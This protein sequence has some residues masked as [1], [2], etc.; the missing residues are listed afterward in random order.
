MT[1]SHIENKIQQLSEKIRLAHKNHQ[2]LAISGNGSKYFYGHQVQ[3]ED[4][5]STELSGIINYHPSELVIT[6]YAGTPLH[7]I[8][9]ALNANNQMLAFEPPTCRGKATLGGA[10]ASGFSGPRR[11]FAGAA[12]DYMLGCRII[13]G[14]GEVLRFGGEVIKNVAGY[15]VSRLMCGAF[16]TLGLLIEVSLKV[17]PVA[18]CEVTTSFELDKHKSIE[19]VNHL[20]TQGAPLSASCIYD[21]VLSIRFSGSR[22]AVD[23]TVQSLGGDVIE[24]AD[25]FWL[26]IQEQGHDFFNHS[27][28]LWRI[29]VPPTTSSI[30]LEGDEL[31]E[32]YGGLR[33]LRTNAESNEIHR[34]TNAL[35]GHATLYKTANESADFRFSPLS[36][37]VLRLHKNLKHAFDPRKILNP[38]KLYPEI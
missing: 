38:K 11:A 13:N 5:F 30:D 9:A 33:W 4:I 7:E 22:I 16:G 6:A 23:K 29:S 35:G 25:D 27:E 20:A 14:K 36:K 21:G 32:W 8:N 26:G 28:D 19:F 2:A 17:V 18:E 31:I 10:V 24:N 37:P 3:G 12:R 1:D 34:I 15:D